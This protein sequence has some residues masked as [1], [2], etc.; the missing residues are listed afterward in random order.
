MLVKSNESRSLPSVVALKE[1]STLGPNQSGGAAVAAA[2][3][4][5]DELSLITMAVLSAAGDEEMGLGAGFDSLD[6]APLKQK[7][8]KLTKVQLLRSEIE[9]VQTRQS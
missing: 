7:V 1:K 5:S 2:A 3:T 8:V 4:P 6:R 9:E